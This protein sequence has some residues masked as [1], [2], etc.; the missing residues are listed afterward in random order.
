VNRYNPKGGERYSKSSAI[1]HKRKGDPRPPLPELDNC[2]RCKG[3]R[4]GVRGNENWVDGVLLCDYC[5]ADQMK[6]GVI[7][8]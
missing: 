7:E 5:H 4:G 1:R 6:P 3:E 8:R 2:S